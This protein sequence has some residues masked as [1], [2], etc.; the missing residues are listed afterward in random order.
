M[1]AHWKTN[2]NLPL[3]NLVVD[4][5]FTVMLSKGINIIIKNMLI[6]KNSI[7]TNKNKQKNIIFYNYINL[8]ILKNY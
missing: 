7:N 1:N 3:V 5:N 8:N 2:V 6:I 4:K